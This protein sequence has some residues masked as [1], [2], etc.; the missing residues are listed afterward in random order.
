M[1]ELTTSGV[2]ERAGV[3]IHTVRYYEKR[4]LL[5]EPPRTISGYRK[6]GPEHVS[7]IRFIKR[8]QELGFT[9]EEI[10]DLLRLRVV[11]GAGAEVRAWTAA[12]IEEI[13]GKID[14]LRRIRGKLVELSTGC[15]R[16][17]SSE[18]CL[19]LHA[20]EDPEAIGY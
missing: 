20:L 1:Q 2:A 12:K 4:G 16:H 8:A 17:G 3:N 6:Y 7:Q 13:D 9:L 19:V 10:D 15:D 18:S 5:P 11:P 14:D